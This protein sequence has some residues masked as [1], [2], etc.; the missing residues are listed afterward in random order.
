LPL[1]REALTFRQQMADED[2]RNARVQLELVSTLYS[3]ALL[4]RQNNRL[5]E[6]RVVTEKA[7]KVLDQL[8]REGKLQGTPSASWPGILEQ[9]LA[10]CKAA[11]VAVKDLALV[12]KEPAVNVPELLRIHAFLQARAGKWDDAVAAADRLVAL[13]SR[14]VPALYDAARIYA[15]LSADSRIDLKKAEAHAAKAITLL[16]QARTAGYFQSALRRQRLRENEDLETLR[17]SA[18]F[19]QLLREVD[20]RPGK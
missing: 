6:S 15:V 3:V 14:D 13:S 2:P 19:Q 18:A 12:L 8:R 20:A 11:E 5:G 7:L 10:F 9:H 4:E 16:Q 17:K 1:F